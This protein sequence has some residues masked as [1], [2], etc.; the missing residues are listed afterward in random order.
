VIIDWLSETLGTGVTVLDGTPQAVPLPPKR[1][2]D[3]ERLGR[4]GGGKDW[5]ITYYICGT[6]GRVTMALLF[7]C[8]PKTEGIVDTLPKPAGINRSSRIADMI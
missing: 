8:Q 1:L 6:Q 4:F 5:L 3:T 7:Y 2:A